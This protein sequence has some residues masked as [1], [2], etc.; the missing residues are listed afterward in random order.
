MCYYDY[1]IIKFFIYITYNVKLGIRNIKSKIINQ[2][3]NDICYAL[4]LKNDFY[5]GAFGSFYYVFTP[6]MSGFQCDE[7]YYV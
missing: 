2:H 6:Q 3:K 1:T 4:P 7:T 5:F